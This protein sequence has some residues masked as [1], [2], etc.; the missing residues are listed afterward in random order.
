LRIDHGL[1][2]CAEAVRAAALALD[3]E[4]SLATA[5]APEETGK[6]E[7]PH[8]TCVQTFLSGLPQ[9]TGGRRGATGRLEDR[10]S[11][12]PLE[13]FVVLFADW[14][15]DYNHCPH[16]ELHGRSPVEAFV[17]DPTP[18]RTLAIEDARALLAARKTARVHRYGVSHAGHRYTSPDL[19]E[20]VGEEVQIAFAPHDQRSVDVYWLGEWVCTAF[21]QETRTEE[22]KREVIDARRQHAQELRRRQRTAAR[23]ARTRL[24]PITDTER[25]AVEVNKP[26]ATELT[27]GRER[28][29][30]DAARTDLLIV[31][32]GP[33]RA[34]RTV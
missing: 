2:F 11:P 30:T 15:R 12:V 16:S 33:P 21:P 1:E 25:Q 19:H 32:D 6:I 20:L 4:F 3:V 10:R 8:R 5:Y 27:V 7:R 17:S 31:R 14:V 23:K 9:Y 26:R 13:R 18:L 24:A 22:Q 34:T 28:S 29:L